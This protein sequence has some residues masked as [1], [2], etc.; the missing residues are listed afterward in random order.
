MM[1]KFKFLDKHILIIEDRT[2]FSMGL[3]W[4]ILRNLSLIDKTY[5]A[6]DFRNY[7]YNRHL[8]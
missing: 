6:G 3:Y 5:L 1:W 2:Y 8:C 7:F 4:F